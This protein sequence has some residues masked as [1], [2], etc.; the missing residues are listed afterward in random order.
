MA[1]IGT[2]DGGVYFE[3][4]NKLSNSTNC[5]ICKYIAV[6]LL[7]FEQRCI[8]GRIEYEIENIS[9][10]RQWH[11]TWR[12]MTTFQITVVEEVTDAESEECEQ[13]QNMG[14]HYRLIRGYL[15]DIYRHCLMEA[16]SICKIDDD[17]YNI[18]YITSLSSISTSG[19][20][21]N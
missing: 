21:L 10:E 8:S 13:Q 18:P 15:N 7:P 14:R 12:Q 9:K 1:T 5:P 17:S 20:Y 6:P 4:I 16:D 3:M 11:R 19:R 2:S